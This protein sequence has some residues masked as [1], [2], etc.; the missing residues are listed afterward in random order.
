MANVLFVTGDLGGNLPPAIGIATE[1]RRRGHRVRFLGHE[2]QW[3]VLGGIAFP[4]EAY[5]QR[6]VERLQRIR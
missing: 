2:Q 4:F 6:P 1:L 3:E 5:T